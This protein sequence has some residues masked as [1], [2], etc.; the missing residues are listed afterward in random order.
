M[1]RLPLSSIA[2]FATKNGISF[3]VYAVE[4]GKR[5]IFS[6]CVTDAP[7]DGKHVNL[8]IHEA[9][10]IQQYS[11]IR[12]FSRLISGQIH[13]HNGSVYCCKKCLHACSSA[14]VL[15]RHTQRC[16]HVQLSKFPK[17]TSCRFTNTQKQLQAPFVV[18]ADFESVLTPLSNIDTTQGVEEEGE[19]SIVPYQEHVACS[20][21]YKIV[22]SVIP[23]FNRPIV[24]YRG[25]DA[26]DEYIRV[27]QREAEELC[28]QFIESPQEMEFTEE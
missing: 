15:K 26:A 12:N 16:T 23:E 6:L 13:N 21:S 7:V 17:D 10:E 3:N 18:Y 4:D 22:S 5:V 19:P 28:S 1:C 9:N 25:E 11:T 27:L 14:D 20:F 8:L 2:P 24:W